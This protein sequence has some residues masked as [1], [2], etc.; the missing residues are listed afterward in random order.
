MNVTS[1][2]VIAGLLTVGGRWVQDKPLDVKIGIGAAFVILT[3]SFLN[4]SNPALANAFAWL[5]LAGAFLTNG[6]AL[7]QA[8]G[9]QV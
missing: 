1:K 6:V 4:G 2:V 8:I 9:K 7:F 3:L 5:I